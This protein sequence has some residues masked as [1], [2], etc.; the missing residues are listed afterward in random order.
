[1]HQFLKTLL[2]ASGVSILSGCSTEALNRLFSENKLRELQIEARATAN[3]NHATAV[4]IV[5]VYDANLEE[6][7]PKTA[8][9]WFARKSEIASNYPG[10]FDTVSLEIP[11]AMAINVTNFPDKHKAAVLVRSYAKMGHPSTNDSFVLTEYECA[12]ITLTKE[13]STYQECD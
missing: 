7:M 2:A 9:Q 6:R 8:T 10:G 11:S 1:M 5:F 13:K 4:D 3:D 12:K